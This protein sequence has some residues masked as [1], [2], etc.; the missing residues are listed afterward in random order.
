MMKHFGLIAFSV[1]SLISCKNFEKPEPKSDTVIVEDSTQKSEVKLYTLNGGEIQ[2]NKKNLFAQGDTYK[3]DTIVLADAFYV[4]KHP[5]GNLIWDTGLSEE[6]VGKEPKSVNEGALVLSRKDSLSVQLDQIGLTPSDFDFIAFSHIHF[7]HTGGGNYFKD[8]TWLIQ[9]TEY[10]FATGEEIKS[11]GFYNTNDFKALKNV[12]QLKGDFDVFGDGTVIIKSYPG[13]TPGHQALFLDLENSGPILLSG[14]VY[15]FEENR[16]NKIIPQFNHDIP[17][18]E[19]SIEQFE[20]FVS[21]KRA[22][23]YIQHDA[24]HFNRMPK[25][26]K[27]IN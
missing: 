21:D 23:V 6:L 17:Q 18:T 14:D 4:I 26:P 11:Q 12:K 3:G 24:K 22:K 20:K 27:F 1:L 2:V 13:H 25:S 8:A 7:D 10:A 16:E 5:K 19:Q 15:H 9:D